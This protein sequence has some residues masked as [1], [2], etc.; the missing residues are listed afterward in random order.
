MWIDAND[1]IS[2]EKLL[3]VIHDRE[4]R[5]NTD[6]DDDDVSKPNLKAIVQYTEGGYLGDSDIFAVIE[7]LSTKHAGRDASAIADLDTSIFFL[8]IK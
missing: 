8:P 3:K 4:K 2:N 6:S 1:Y 7:G 5:K